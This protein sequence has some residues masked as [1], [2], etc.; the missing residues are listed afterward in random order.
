MWILMFLFACDGDTC[1]LGEVRRDGQCSPYAPGD[2][3]SGDTV[4]FP[5]GL[6]WQ[7][8]LTEALDSSHDVAVYDVDLF[9]VD[10]DVVTGLHDE[11]RLVICYFSGGSFEGWRPDADA[12]PPEVIGRQLDGWP[13][14]RW[15]DTTSGVVRTVMEARLDL[16]RDLGCDAVEP[17]NMT[18][19][20]ANSGFGINPTEQLD[21][22][23]FIA[24]AAHE[25]DLA[26]AL[27]NDTEQVAE[28]VDWFDLQV[29]EECAFYNEC[30]TLAPFVDAD[31]AVLHAE[32]VDDFADAPALAAQ[33]CGVEPGLS[34]IVKTWDLGPE[35]QACP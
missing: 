5:V 24:D 21:Y 12:F 9:R 3:V 30:D 34:T 22:N 15:L 35:L 13:D 23:R 20:D 33:V 27:K 29:N 31:K 1:D 28:L 10:A 19:W 25:R 32:Y 6:S 18:A 17:D 8:Q 7:W 16:A 2:P 26:V 4:G 11:G 14:E